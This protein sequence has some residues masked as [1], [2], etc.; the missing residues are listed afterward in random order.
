MARSQKLIRGR[1]VIN[2]NIIYETEAYHLG[3]R[4]FR[5]CSCCLISSKI[6]DLEGD[7]IFFVGKIIL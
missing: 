1:M 5:L 3:Q 7:L 2:R 6:V 4:M